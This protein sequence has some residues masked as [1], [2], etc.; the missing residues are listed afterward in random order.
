MKKRI[1]LFLS[2][3]LIIFGLSACTFDANGGTYTIIQYSEDGKIIHEYKNVKSFMYLDSGIKLTTEDGKNV[4]LQ[5][6]VSAIEQNKE[7]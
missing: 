4:G 3:T 7:E 2:S 6:T 1:I 5:G